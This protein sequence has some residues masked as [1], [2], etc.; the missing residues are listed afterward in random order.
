[1]IFLR[2]VG[3]RPP[4]PF[5]VLRFCFPINIDEVAAMMCWNKVSSVSP[6]LDD[7][8]SHEGVPY[9]S[10]Y[11]RICCLSSDLGFW[12]VIQAEQLANH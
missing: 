12:C 2:G 4:I 6:Y 7:V 11:P 5:Y 1:M 8:R 3:T 9:E 10:L